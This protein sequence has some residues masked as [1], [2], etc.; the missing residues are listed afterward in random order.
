[1]ECLISEHIATSQYSAGIC[2]CKHMCICVS[3]TGI[4]SNN[5][6]GL[7]LPQSS[8]ICKQKNKAVPGSLKLK[9]TRN[10][11]YVPCKSSEHSLNLTTS[12][13]AAP[14]IGLLS[15]VKSTFTLKHFPRHTQDNCLN[16]EGSLWFTY[17]VFGPQLQ[18]Y[19]EMPSNL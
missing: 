2:V 3:I 6:E 10:W 11:D 8:S 13:L 4:G 15:L 1:M 16:I 12:D 19:L 7:E 9:S 17:W 14:R 18:C 5:H